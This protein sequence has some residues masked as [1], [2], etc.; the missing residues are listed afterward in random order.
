MARFKEND[1]PKS[2][3]QQVLLIKR[4]LF[5]YAET[6]VEILCGSSFYLLGYRFSVS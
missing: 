2:K 1:L 5:N 4:R 3:L 6:T